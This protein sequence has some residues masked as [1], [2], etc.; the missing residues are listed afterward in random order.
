[1][2]HEDACEVEDST[3][4]RSPNVKNEEF[5]IVYPKPYIGSFFPERFLR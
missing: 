5:E 1:M 2:I 4:I 3:P